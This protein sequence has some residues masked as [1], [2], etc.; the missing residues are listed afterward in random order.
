MIELAFGLGGLLLGGVLGGVAVWLVVQQR[1]TQAGTERAVLGTRIASL[2]TL[3]KELG[4][5]LTERQLEIADLRAAA[6]SE[7]TERARAEERWQAERRNLEE[8]RRF[9]EEARTGLGETFKAL[10]A[11][12]LN[13]TSA[14]LFERARET[15]DAQLG[16]REQS[17]RS[18][19]DPL[20][21]ALKRAEAQVR[22]LESAREHA[23]GSLE[24]R[25]RALSE[26]SQTLTR[27]TH[28][29]A[30]ALRASQARGRWGEIA[31]R[32]VVELAGMTEH[33]D[34]VEQVTADGE[35]GRVRPDMVVRLPAGREIVLDSKVPLSA[36]LDAIDAATPEERQQ[37]FSRH[38]A[39]LRQHMQ[40]LAGK[41]YWK[42]FA[43]S[44][45][46]V[47]MFIPGESFVAAAVEADPNLLTDAMEKRVIVA[48]PVTLFALLAAIAYGWQ[49]Q[50]VARSAEEIRKLGQDL[51]D[52]L[53]M[54]GGHVNGVG[55]ALGRAVEA[56]NDAVG[57]LERRVLPAARRFRDLGVGTRDE[58]PTLEPIDHDPRRLTASEF[59]I[60]LEIGSKGT[61]D[62]K[63]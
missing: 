63:G 12:A 34:F 47:I 2:E 56:Y 37:G 13:Q 43:Q 7:R 11:D 23:Y 6:D 59:S 4:R 36:Y 19:L 39:Q 44:P 38:A 46:L 8:Q 20:Q 40:Q 15:V 54:L 48:T 31:L 45:D 1:I 42:Q 57:S 32:R 29:L 53:A 62:E 24:E 28:S 33:C 5:Q 52:R 55:A 9:V 27:E 3:E 58:I 41:A 22:Q 26:Q 18:L 49:Q 60:Q 61:P 50:R 51:Y 21:E 17:L 35:G 10:S 30:S 14:I 16:R 25:L